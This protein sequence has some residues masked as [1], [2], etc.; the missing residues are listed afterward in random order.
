MYLYVYQT[1]AEGKY[2]LE[3]ENND[4]QQPISMG[5]AAVQFKQERFI[6]QVLRY[7]GNVIVV[8]YLVTRA[9]QVMCIYAPQ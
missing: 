7:A 4:V 1:T 2:L 8:C 6:L 9:C 3:T 5:V